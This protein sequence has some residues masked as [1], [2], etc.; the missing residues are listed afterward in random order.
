MQA[1]LMLLVLM[2]L[3]DLNDCRHWLINSVQTVV[4]AKTTSI[5]S[6]AD[7]PRY[8][9]FIT[10]Y[11]LY[12][13]CLE[14]LQSLFMVYVMD[15]TRSARFDSC[16]VSVSQWWCREGRPTCKCT[17]ALGKLAPVLWQYPGSWMIKGIYFL[18]LIFLHSTVKNTARDW[19]LWV[20]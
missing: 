3:V 2:L 17:T 13:I 11:L 1:I 9:L 12:W 18:E 16:W 14:Q 19:L 4:H 20:M 10:V 6:A 7:L 15:F 8:Y 5:V